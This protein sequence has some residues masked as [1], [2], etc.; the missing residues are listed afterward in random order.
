[1]RIRIAEQCKHAHGVH[2]SADR[3]KEMLAFRILPGTRKKAG[4]PLYSVIPVQ[5]GTLPLHTQNN[6]DFCELNIENL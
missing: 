5:T 1:M 6:V 2:P 4:A 3:K